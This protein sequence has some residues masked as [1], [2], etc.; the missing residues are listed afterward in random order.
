MKELPEVIVK[1]LLKIGP[2]FHKVLMEKAP[3][4]FVL[5]G[6]L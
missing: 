6:Y 2:H 5:F 1:Q 4:L 3:G